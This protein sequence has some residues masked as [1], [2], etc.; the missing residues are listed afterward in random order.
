MNST[1]CAACKYLRRRCSPDCIFSPYFPPNNPQR[2]LEVH[3]IYGASNVAKMLEKAPVNQR[4]EAANSI[5]YEAHCRIK[6]PVYGCAGII[7]LLNQQINDAQC[8]LAKIQ[9]EIAAHN[10]H[11]AGILPPYQQITDA[12]SFPN[13]PVEGD[14]AFPATHD[15]SFPQFY[16]NS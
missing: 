1:R 16:L 3:R 15:P 12:S 6:D 7:T 14:G 4:A 9:A 2:F 10:G 5:H 8:E 11:H 13:Y